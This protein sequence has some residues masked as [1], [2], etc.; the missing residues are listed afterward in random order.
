MARVVPVSLA[1]NPRALWFDPG[2][3]E[4]ADQDAVVVQTTRGMEFGRAVGE[5]FEV[6]DAQVKALKSPLKPVLRL[7]TD[8][9]EEAAAEMEERGREALP[10]FKEMAAEATGSRNRPMLPQDQPLV[11]NFQVG[12]WIRLMPR[13]L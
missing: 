11:Q 3:L 8:E 7:A 12:S 10:V 5:P 4:I 1:H 6:D 13:K 9:D 2:E